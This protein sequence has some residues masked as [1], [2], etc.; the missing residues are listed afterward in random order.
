DLIAVTKFDPVARNIVFNTYIG[1]GGSDSPR[2]I[3]VGPSAGELSVYVAGNT[4]SH[5]FPTCLG[6]SDCAAHHG[7]ND[8]FLVRVNANTG[9]LRSSWLLG[10]SG[11][12]FANGV[13]LD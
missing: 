5:D 12:D 13:A 3:A 7:G 10:G 2:A 1:G 6:T 8:A 9:V 4:T 11:D